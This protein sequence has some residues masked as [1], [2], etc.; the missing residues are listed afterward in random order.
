MFAGAIDNG[1]AVRVQFAFL[2]QDA[3]QSDFALSPSERASRL[4]ATP[5]S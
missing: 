5:W 1:E 2:D 4:V 3:D